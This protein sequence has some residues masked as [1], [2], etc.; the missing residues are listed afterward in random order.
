MDVLLQV[1]VAALA[2]FGLGAAAWLLFGRL[3]TPIGGCAHVPVF[4]V[5][6]AIGDAEGLEQTVDG[7]LWL[8]RSVW[9]SVRILLLD[10][11]L[12]ETGWQRAMHL[13]ERG[14]YVLYC[15]PDAIIEVIDTI[16]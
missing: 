4:A 6:R 9:P 8:S 16:R 5:V 11:G 14:P 1:I 2:A 10:E 13:T 15:T 12:T 3:L 7:L